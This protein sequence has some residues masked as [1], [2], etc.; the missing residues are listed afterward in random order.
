MRLRDEIDSPNA[1][2]SRAARLLGAVRPKPDDRGAF[3][4][5]LAALSGSGGRRRRSR[6]RLAWGLGALLLAGLASAMIAWMIHRHHSSGDRIGIAG[7]APTA[8]AKISAAPRKIVDGLARSPISAPVSLATVAGG[9][10][11]P[12]ARSPSVLFAHRPDRGAGARLRDR[13]TGPTVEGDSNSVARPN[14]VSA[15]PKAAAQREADPATAV[16]APDSSLEAQLLVDALNAVRRDHDPARAMTLIDFY[17]ERYPRG[18]LVEEALALAV[19]AAVAEGPGGRAVTARAA[20][21]RARFPSGRYRGRV[22]ELVA[23]GQR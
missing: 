6:P 13:H 14:P 16:S 1:A 15:R 21:Y 19:E 12:G 2:V 4:R 17:L 5:V 11:I 23:S 9:E 3:R 7:T 18:V 20:A 22:E 8:V 10:K